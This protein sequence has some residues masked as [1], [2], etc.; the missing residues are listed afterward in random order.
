MLRNLTF[1][2]VPHT[3]RNQNVRWLVLQQDSESNG[4]F[5]FMHQSRTMPSLFDAWFPTHAEALQ[6]A[7]ADWGVDPLSWQESM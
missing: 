6:Q 2:E 7:Q 1:A 5:L 3:H 4:W